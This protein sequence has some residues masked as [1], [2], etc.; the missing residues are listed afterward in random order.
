[1]KIILLLLVVSAVACEQHNATSAALD[2]E[3]RQGVEY[4]HARYLFTHAEYENVEVAVR[5]ELRYGYPAIL[6]VKDISPQ[7]SDN[8]IEKALLNKNGCNLSFIGTSTGVEGGEYTGELQQ[9]GG[10]VNGCC[11][12]MT[13]VPAIDTSLTFRGKKNSSNECGRVGTVGGN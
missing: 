5:V 12:K 4:L 7:A 9:T 11:G 1:M 2:A 6:Q 8:V 10:K 3:A 13:F